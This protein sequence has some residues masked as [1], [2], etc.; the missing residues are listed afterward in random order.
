MNNQQ[1][2]FEGTNQPPTFEGTNQPPTFEST[3]QP[4]TFEGIQSSQKWGNES[5]A[6]AE[7]FNDDN[8]FTF[9]A[10]N[11]IS[12]FVDTSAVNGFIFGEQKTFGN[13]AQGGLMPQMFGGRGGQFNQSQQPQQNQFK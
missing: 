3:N 6:G 4:P 2:T 10:Q 11:E 9:D 8:N 5:F 1:S 13:F 12:E 7:I